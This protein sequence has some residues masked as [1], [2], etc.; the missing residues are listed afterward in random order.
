MDGKNG[1]IVWFAMDIR[2]MASGILEAKNFTKIWEKQEGNQPIFHAQYYV[3]DNTSWIIFKFLV[4]SY[5]LVRSS[6][7]LQ[8]KVRI[9]T[10]KAS[11]TV[12]VSP[13]S[14]EYSYKGDKKWQSCIRSGKTENNCEDTQDHLGHLLWKVQIVCFTFMFHFHRVSH[15]HAQFLLLE[16]VIH[17]SSFPLHLH[18]ILSIPASQ[19]TLP[20]IYWFIISKLSTFSLNEWVN[21]WWACKETGGYVW[22]WNC[23]QRLYLS[24]EPSTLSYTRLLLLRERSFGVCLVFISFF[25]E[26]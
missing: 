2:H 17:Q 9:T 3:L 11:T 12:V 18:Y 15:K 4:I 5:L 7:S 21:E 23:I 14:G 1:G 10:V 8:V 25:I 6:Y 26:V 13:Q 16:P 20:P 19:I 22:F 24:L